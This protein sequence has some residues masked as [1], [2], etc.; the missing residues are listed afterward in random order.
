MKN[1]KKELQ[2]LFENMIMIILDRLILILIE[3]FDKNLI[4]LIII[5]KFVQNKKQ[6]INRNYSYFRVNVL[7]IF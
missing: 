1:M 2:I 4:S 6:F 3:I 7:L 5:N